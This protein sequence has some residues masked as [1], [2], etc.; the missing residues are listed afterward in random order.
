MRQPA[1]FSDHHPRIKAMPLQPQT[2][3]RPEED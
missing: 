3:Q 1:I 2:I